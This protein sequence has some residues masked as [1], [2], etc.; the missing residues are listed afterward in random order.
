MIAMT[1]IQNVSDSERAL[2]KVGVIISELNEYLSSYKVIK[3]EVYEKLDGAYRTIC[4][5]ET[6]IEMTES[7][8]DEFLVK[9]ADKWE[10]DECKSSAWASKDAMESIFKYN[11]L[12]FVS[13]WF[14]DLE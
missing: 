12:L 8:T 11:G 2:E 13:S 7:I 14:E 3:N 9:I 5:I 4:N 10:W 6:K 1:F